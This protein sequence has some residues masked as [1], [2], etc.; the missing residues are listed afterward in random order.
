MDFR[1]LSYVKAI[2]E[3]QNL[4]KA[5]EALYVGQPTLSKFLAALEAELGVKLFRKVGHRYALTYAGERYV[6]RAS[7]ILRNKAALDAEMA[8]IRMREV[9]ELSIAFANMRSGYTLP[10]VLPKFQA[11]YPN[12]RVRSY[13]DDSDANDRR[14]LE[15][16]VEIAFY[17]MPTEANPLLEYIPLVREELLICTSHGYPLSRF[18]E[19]NPDN[20]HPRLPLSALKGERVLMMQPE[21]RTRQIVDAILREKKLHFDD[22]V[23]MSS[24]QAILG[25]VARGYGVSFAF[26]THLNHRADTPPI[27]RYSFGTPRTLRDFVAAKRRSAELSP[28]A[29]AFIDIVREAARGGAGHM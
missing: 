24:L 23:C 28:W 4:T 1:A 7:D 26:D 3:H 8:D 27:D 9:G 2:A 16:Q 12:V 22:V 6:A 25:L 20:P 21:Q 29:R 5:A 17:A 15:G 10:E 11:V 14:L 18:A 13:E 19:P